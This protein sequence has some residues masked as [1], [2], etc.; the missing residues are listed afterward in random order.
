MMC[1]R[2]LNCLFEVVNLEV[3]AFV[4]F[5]LGGDLAVFADDAVAGFLAEG[6]IGQDD[7]VG[8]RC[9]R[10]TGHRPGERGC[11]HCPGR[12]DTSSWRT[13]ARPRR[14]ISMPVKASLRSPASLSRSLGLV[15]SYGRR[16]RAEIRRCR[17]GGAWIDHGFADFRV[18]ALDHRFDDRGAG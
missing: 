12:A 9:R 10:W 11:H 17:R 4:V 18:E 1:W 3:F 8:G 2:K 16:Q 6:R 5:L 14:R 13:G 7:V 15:F